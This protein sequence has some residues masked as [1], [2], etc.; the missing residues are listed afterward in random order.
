MFGLQDG[1][2]GGCAGDLHLPSKGEPFHPCLSCPLQL[3][4]LTPSGLDC[5]GQ[6]GGLWEQSW[7]AGV[8]SRVA[9]CL[10]GPGFGKLCYNASERLS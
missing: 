2:L 4:E 8:L 7:T 9:A 5:L 6:A 1:H 3:P 10:W